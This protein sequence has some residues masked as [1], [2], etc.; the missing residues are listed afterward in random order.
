MVLD[1]FRHRPAAQNRTGPVA[2]KWLPFFKKRAQI[3]D[4][5]LDNDRILICR[6][7]VDS[8]Q[9]NGD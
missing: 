7:E 4:M 8:A 2:G 5:L 3:T 1:Y 6:P 9:A